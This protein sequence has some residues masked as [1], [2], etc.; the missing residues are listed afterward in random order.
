MDTVATGA[1]PD[2]SSTRLRPNF[3]DTQTGLRAFTECSGSAVVIHVGGDIDAS[4]KT[5]WQRLLSRSASIA[6][7]PGPFV[8]DVRELEFMGSC[9]YAVLAREAERCKSRGVLLRLVSSQPVV[10]QTIAACGLL[11]LL[12]IYASVD[13][14][15]SPTG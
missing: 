8:I 1:F 3:G 13:N 4:N 12:P 14:A 15:L 6:I 5:S 11:R 7:A 10:A 9:G 2:S